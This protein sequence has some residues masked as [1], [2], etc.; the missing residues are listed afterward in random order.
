MHSEMP[1]LLAN[2]ITDVGFIIALSASFGILICEV[3]LCCYGEFAAE[4]V[5]GYNGNFAIFFGAFAAV[6]VVVWMGR[7]A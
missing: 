7:F 6:I 4:A 3:L 5:G 1:Y 2:S